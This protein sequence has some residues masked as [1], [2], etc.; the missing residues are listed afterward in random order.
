VKYCQY[1]HFA[2][3]ALHYNTITSV[4]NNQGQYDCENK[5]QTHKQ[6]SF[7]TKRALVFITNAFT[8]HCVHRHCETNQTKGN[9]YQF[10]QC[11][12]RS[13]WLEFSFQT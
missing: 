7:G 13:M 5:D 12:F 4:G 3:D 11:D 1:I 10:R 2:N 6:C 9:E 8:K